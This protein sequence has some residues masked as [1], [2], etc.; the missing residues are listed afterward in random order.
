MVD[1]VLDGDAPGQAVHIV[2]GREN[3]VHNDMLGDQL[4]LVEE[5]LVDELLPAVLLQQLLQ[6]A[7]PD[8][9]FDLAGL[10]GIEVHIAAHIA[11]A[12]GDH[13]KG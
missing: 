13:P 5:N 3:I 8:P 4:V 11:H 9:L 7:E 10:K 12:V 6:D 2:D 1:V